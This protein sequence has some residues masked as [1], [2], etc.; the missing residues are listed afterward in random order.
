MLW[1]EILINV[2]LKAVSHPAIHPRTRGKDI[3]SKRLSTA[4]VYRLLKLHS[5]AAQ[6]YPQLFLCFHIPEWLFAIG[7][8]VCI[9]S[10]TIVNTEA[11]KKLVF[12]ISWHFIYCLSALVIALVLA[13]QG[14]PGTSAQQEH[15][16]LCCLQE[17]PHAGE[18]SFRPLVLV[19][20]S[21]QIF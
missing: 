8:S 16:N 17:G 18:P 3:H 6:S 2:F 20:K 1:I 11:S 21:N 10:K 9:W 15:E 13:V 12:S 14:P 19:S 4:S 5:K 7:H